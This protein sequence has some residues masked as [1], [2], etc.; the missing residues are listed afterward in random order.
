MGLVVELNS[1]ETIAPVHKKQLLTYLRLMDKQ[2]GLWINFNVDLLKD[3]LT[4]IVK[5]L[6]E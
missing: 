5:R 3:G 4:R 6:P 2:V 1:V